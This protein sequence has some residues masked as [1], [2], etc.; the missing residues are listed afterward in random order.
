MPEGDDLDDS[1]QGEYA[2]WQEAGRPSSESQRHP[3][4]QPKTGPPIG[5]DR[6]GRSAVRIPGDSGSVNESAPA[7]GYNMHRVSHCLPLVMVGVSGQ[8]EQFVRGERKVAVLEDF[9]AWLV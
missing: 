2:M 5:I 6:L 4:G 7:T 8:V 9:H 1:E 3:Q